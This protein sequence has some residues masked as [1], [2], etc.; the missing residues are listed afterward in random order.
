M[1]VLEDSQRIRQTPCIHSDCAASDPADLDFW[2][3]VSELPSS[4]DAAEQTGFAVLSAPLGSAG[5]PAPSSDSLFSSSELFALAQPGWDPVP[6]APPFL[7]AELITNL[8]EG[9]EHIPAKAEQTNVLTSRGSGVE[10][11]LP[12]DN[13]G[14]Q[15]SFADGLERKRATNRANQRSFRQKQRSGVNAWLIITCRVLAESAAAAAESAHMQLR[16][17]LPA[18][19]R[20]CR[21]SE[22]VSNNWK[23]KISFWKSCPQSD[24]TVQTT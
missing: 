20:S 22:L 23:L 7:R 19:C 15:D 12:G 11:S 1:A 21:S 16:H 13:S 5:V 4:L 8:A 10:A 2:Q 24:N 9:L 3:F 14:Q 18:Q 6:S 17:S